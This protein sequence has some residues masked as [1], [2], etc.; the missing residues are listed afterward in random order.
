MPPSWPAA[1]K[2][3][4]KLAQPLTN[5]STQETGPRTSSEQHSGASHVCK[6][7]DEPARTIKEQ[8]SCTSPLPAAALE[9]VSL[10]P[11]VGSTVELALGLWM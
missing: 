5:G 7:I 6:G 10:V 8:E 2:R 11:E 1:V 3:V 4:G 9:R